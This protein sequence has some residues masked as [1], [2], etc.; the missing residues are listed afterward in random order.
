MSDLPLPQEEY[1]QALRDVYHAA[2][3][4]LAVESDE[5]SRINAMLV[6][7][8]IL[9]ALAVAVMYGETCTYA[10]AVAP[11]V[12]LLAG[13]AVCVAW[14]GKSNAGSGPRI[15]M[16]GSSRDSKPSFPK[17]SAS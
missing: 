9:I 5:W 11:L 15:A 7:H 6:A 3:E 17:T 4:Y 14:W 2:R 12:L 13:L 16:W 8:A 1:R 10:P